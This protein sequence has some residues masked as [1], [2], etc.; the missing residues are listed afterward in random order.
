MYYCFNVT[1]G[2]IPGKPEAVL[3]RAL[4]PVDGADIMAKRRGILNGK[5]RD[6]TNG[7]GKLCMAMGI[8]KVQNKADLT[9]PPLYVKDAPSIRSEDIVDATRVGVDY[10]GEWKDKSLRFYIRGNRFVSI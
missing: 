3:I 6:L 9:V 5:F 8:S 10:A 1:S 7:P 2:E 4:E